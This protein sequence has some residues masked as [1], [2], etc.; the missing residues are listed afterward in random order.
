MD[1]KLTSVISD[2]RE[3]TGIE[4]TVFNMVGEKVAYTSSLISHVFPQQGIEKFKNGILIDAEKDTSYFLLN[5]PY[6][7]YMGAINGSDTIAKNYAIMISSMIE[8]LSLQ[9]DDNLSQHEAI[10]QI[11]IGEST[12]SKIHKA[13]RRYSQI[14]LPCYVLAV[15]CAPDKVTDIYNF[16]EQLSGDVGDTA[17]VTDEDVIAYLKIINGGDTDYQSALDFAEMIWQNIEQELH[18]KVKIG[19]GSFSKNAFEL[20]GAYLQGSSAVRMGI[21]SGGKTSI[22]SYKEFIMVRMIEDIPKGTLSKYLEILMDAGAKEILKDDEMLGTAEEFLANSLNISETARHL[23]MHR[24]TLMYR[25]D[26]IE[27]AMGLNIRR[28]S[29]AVTF[30]IIIILYK[31]L[32][33]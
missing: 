32:K 10:K 30:R 7:L 5:T 21:T 24:N 4:I 31:H 18:V 22:F 20:A 19:V 15:V 33:F 23:Y 1:S 2:I 12:H 27:K 8:N 26:K 9:N 6:S 3:K 25:L 28:F 16:L 17:V 11:L 14:N 13:V 29:D